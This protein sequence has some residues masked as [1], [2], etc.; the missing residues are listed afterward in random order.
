MRQSYLTIKFL[1]ALS[2][3]LFSTLFDKASEGQAKDMDAYNSFADFCANKSKLDKETSHTVER[4]LLAAETSDCEIANKLLSN[5]TSI[6]LP[7][8]GISSLLPF[9]SLKKLVQLR[10]SENQ[11]SDL[12]I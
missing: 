5:A 10:L 6:R 8:E 4:L 9:K 2:C 12:I 3:L 11:I 1:V 7:K